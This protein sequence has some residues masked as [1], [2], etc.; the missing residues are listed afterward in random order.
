MVAV[1]MIS[2]AFTNRYYLMSSSLS[3]GQYLAADEIRL[4]SLLSL[5]SLL[6]SG[7]RSLY[8]FVS[9]VLELMFYLRLDMEPFRT[10]YR[11]ARS[12]REMRPSFVFDLFTIPASSAYR[13]YMKSPQPTS[14]QVLAVPSHRIRLLT[15]LPSASDSKCIRALLHWHP[16]SN[17]PSYTAISYSWL[18]THKIVVDNVWTDPE[19]TILVDNVS[20]NVTRSAYTALRAL[21]SRIRPRTVWIDAIC[22]DQNS[23][24]DKDRQIPLMPHI[25]A[26]ADSVAIWLGPSKTA[27]LATAL[28]DRL[29]IVNRMNRIDPQFK[30]EI[31]VEAARALKRMLRRAWFGRTWVVQEAVRARDGKLVVHYGSARL[32]WTRLSWFMQCLS[33][34]QAL[35]RL[36]NERIGYAGLGVQAV[37]ALG[38]VGLIRRFSLLKGGDP[39][40]SLLFYLLQMFR[41]TCR[42]ACKEPEDRI[43]AL[44]GLREGPSTI[45]KLEPEYRKDLRRLYEAVVAHL[46]ETS[47]LANRLDFL[48]HAGMDY[49][50]NTPGLPSWVPDWSASPLTQPLFGTD[51]SSEL[52]ASSKAGQLLDDTAA[53]AS[54]V[55]TKQ[56]QTYEQLYKSSLDRGA[57]VKE[58]IL[59]LYFDA[60]KGMEPY[61][62]VLEG[63][64][65]E[66]QAHIL[67][68]MTTVGSCYRV[69]QSQG[70]QLEITTLAEWVR[71]AFKG[72]MDD[73]ARSFGSGTASMNPAGHPETAQAA[74]GEVIRR[75][76]EVLCAGVSNGQIDYTFTSAPQR[77][78]AKF[79]KLTELMFNIIDMHERLATQTNGTPLTDDNKAFGNSVLQ[80]TL[81]AGVG[82]RNYEEIVRQTCTRKRFG[83][84]EYGRM[85]LFPGSLKEG[86][87][88]VL[89]AGAKVPFVLR[90]IGRGENGTRCFKLV[91]PAFVEGVMYGEGLTGNDV[92]ET[93]RIS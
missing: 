46:L 25:Y 83:V 6:L 86:D 93:I 26:Q 20:T 70:N 30:Y 92:F 34:D 73:A 67:G 28:V 76:A 51:G 11:D 52:M 4:L 49:S 31:D 53:M 61:A 37:M 47:P 3:P 16:I 71:L 5:L 77:R 87:E 59:A 17:T 44:L 69:P 72:A 75:F 45:F 56:N 79:A 39:S 21:R 38:N 55:H 7:A 33:R 43:F 63:S 90:E 2:V 48:S 65:L 91:G 66:V 18:P 10:S 68:R 8:M 58:D 40:L 41:S 62:K 50:N 27:H 22:I 24:A 78:D 9:S 84:T 54:V 80:D 15:I 60:T 89:V 29:W 88:V 35:L 42:F 13:H 74:R 23:D 1:D 32:D 81:K 57:Q 12:S 85:G 36:L 82:L 19:N 14:L 64:V